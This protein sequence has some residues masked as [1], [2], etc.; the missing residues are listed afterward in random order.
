MSILVFLGAVVLLIIACTCIRI[1]RQWQRGLIERLGKYKRTAEPGLHFLVPFIERMVKVDMRERVI[2]VNP[3]AVITKDNVAVTVDA[4]IYC[5]VTDPVAAIYQI[6]DFTLASTKLAQTNLRN[7]IG[8][9]SLDE[10]LTSRDTL[11]VDLTKTI[12]EAT[13]PWGIKVNKV[14]IQK[15][16]P[17]KDITEAM[18]KQMKA[19]REKRAVI[20]KAEGYRDAKIQKAKGDRQA[21]ILVAE[22][23]A[24]KIE[25]VNVAA[26]KYFIGNAQHLK[27]L[28]TVRDSLQNNAKIIVPSDSRLINIIG[29]IAD[30]HGL[31]AG[32]GTKSVETGKEEAGEKDQ[33]EMIKDQRK[34][35]KGLKK[36]NEELKEELEY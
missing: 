34:E 8:G 27:K 28:E 7:Q 19:E 11:N 23:R 4:I 24:K 5:K 9:M 16:D 26:E 2:D 13:D 1:V 6:T 14:E 12:D 35:I 36:E 3:Q 17:P 22:G 29:N 18:S 32:K 20:L 21:A 30:V 15:I 10:S 25:L 31:S 33:S